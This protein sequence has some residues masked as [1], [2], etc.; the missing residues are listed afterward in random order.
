[1]QYKDEIYRSRFPQVV[2]LNVYNIGNANGFLERIGF[3]IYHT[4]VGIYDMEINYGGHDKALSG[5]V[6]VEK[7]NSAG[8]ELKESLPVG[9]TYYSESEV[10][11]IVEYFG[12]FWHGIDY[13]PFSHNCNHFTEALISNICH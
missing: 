7:G 5:I 12:E 6:V 4:S 9:I 10:D 2:Y 1:M 13:D 11:E 8:L 3:G